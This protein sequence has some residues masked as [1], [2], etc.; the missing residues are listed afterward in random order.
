MVIVH[1]HQ[2]AAVAPEEPSQGHTRRARHQGATTIAVQRAG[3][4][5]YAAGSTIGRCAR[6]RNRRRRRS[7]F[8]STATAEASLMR[9]PLMALRPR[10]QRHRICGCLPGCLGRFTKV[11][12]NGPRTAPA[13]LLQ[14]RMRERPGSPAGLSLLVLSERATPRLTDA[15]LR[16][17]KQERA[18]GARDDSPWCSSCTEPALRVWA[19]PDTRCAA[20]RGRA[21]S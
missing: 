16:P 10:R 13:L 7:R 20:V 5:V 1:R 18:A 17:R 6:E 15:R 9:V 4:E 12:R 11:R 14:R 2:L 21:R 3:P 8:A 19:W